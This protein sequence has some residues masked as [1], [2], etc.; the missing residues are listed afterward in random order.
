ML[1]FFDAFKRIRPFGDAP[2]RPTLSI[3]RITANMNKAI[4][5]PIWDK[6]KCLGQVLL[7]NP[8]RHVWEWRYAS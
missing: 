2:D 4:F 1:F 5:V 7:K 3:F 8:V 6:N